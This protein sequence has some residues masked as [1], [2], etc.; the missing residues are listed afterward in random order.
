MRTTLQLDDEVFELV[1]RLANSRKV[2]LGQTVSDLVR[3]GLTTQ[4]RIRTE[5]GL[6][7]FDLPEDSPLVTMECVKRLENETR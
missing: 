1:R 7:V 4:A 2:S 5:K 6:V 3:K